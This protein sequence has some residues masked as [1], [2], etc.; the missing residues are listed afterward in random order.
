MGF[1]K[2]AGKHLATLKLKGDIQLPAYLE[3]GE[4]IRGT[5]SLNKYLAKIDQTLRKS[6]SRVI[7]EGLI[8]II[9]RNT[10]WIV[11]SIG[12]YEVHLVGFC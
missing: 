1:G 2:K 10:R 7:T 9:P 5:E 4:V 8:R 3:I 11:T 12:N 6:S